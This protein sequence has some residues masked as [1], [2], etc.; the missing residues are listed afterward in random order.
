LTHVVNVRR[1]IYQKLNIGRQII[2]RWI[3]QEIKCNFLKK[4]LY[5]I[6]EK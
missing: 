6:N 5:D 1:V 3:H 4:N 2:N